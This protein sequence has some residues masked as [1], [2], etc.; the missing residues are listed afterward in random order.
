MGF[1]AV[2]IVAKDIQRSIDFYALLDVELKETGGKDH[3]E[4]ITSSGV[5]IML[6]S[7]DLV[8]KINPSWVEP[9]GSGIVLCFLKKSSNEVDE[10][11]SRIVDAGFKSIKS[12]WDAFWGQRYSSVLD[13]DG[14]QIDIFSPL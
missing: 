1:D 13:P 5:R 11:F 9:I 10:C 12:P 7:V 3:F 6:D 14:N 4:G 8:K 2:G